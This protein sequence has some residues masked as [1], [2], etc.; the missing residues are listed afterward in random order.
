MLLRS[1]VVLAELMV[2]AGVQS[3]YAAM[4]NTMATALASG[5][6]PDDSVWDYAG[7]T[8]TRNSWFTRDGVHLTPS[9]AGAIADWL[10][11]QVG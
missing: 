7:Y 9:G 2:F 5:A 11:L 6:W 1:P 10:S 8:A 4:N 3:S